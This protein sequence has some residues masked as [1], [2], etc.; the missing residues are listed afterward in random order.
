MP[1]ERPGKPSRGCAAP[2]HDRKQM[3]RRVERNVC[4]VDVASGKCCGALARHRRST[5]DRRSEENRRSIGSPDQEAET[6][7]AFIQEF[8][9]QGDDGSTTNYDTISERLNARENPTEGGIVHTAGFDEEAGVFRIFD[10]WETREHGERFIRERLMPIVQELMASRPN[11][12]R[13]DREIW[14]E[15][16]EL[17]K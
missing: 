2:G 7:V 17:M 14:Y 13:P 9:I 10:V 3:R 16:H 1:V 11:A 15:L 6:A 8:K 4:V 12:T 5:V